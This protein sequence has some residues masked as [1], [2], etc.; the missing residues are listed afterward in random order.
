MSFFDRS[1]GSKSTF[2]GSTKPVATP[3][4]KIANN[5][6]DGDEDPKTGVQMQNSSVNFFSQ[7]SRRKNNLLQ[8][9]SPRPSTTSKGVTENCGWTF[10]TPQA[11][12]PSSEH[13][14]ASSDA[15]N[16]YHE[17]TPSPTTSK[18]IH[19]SPMEQ[20]ETPF[21]DTDISH[22]QSYQERST[23]SNQNHP[24]YSENEGI[25]GTEGSSSRSL[26]QRPPRSIHR[27]FNRSQNINVTTTTTTRNNTTT[28]TN[29][30]PRTHLDRQLTY[31]TKEMSFPNTTSNSTTTTSSINTS[32]PT[33]Q[34]QAHTQA[35]TTI[36]EE[37]EED[38]GDNSNNNSNNNCDTV[39]E[40]EMETGVVS[41]TVDNVNE[42][43][44]AVTPEN[45]N[46]NMNMMTKN[47]RTKPTHSSRYFASN[48]NYI[49][50]NNNSNTG[51]SGEYTDNNINNSRDGFG[52]ENRDKEIS[53]R[54]IGGGGTTGESN[55]TNQYSSNSSNN[56]SSRKRPV[57]FTPPPRDSHRDTSL[58][59]QRRA[60]IRTEFIQ[61]ENQEQ[62]EESRLESI[63][64][65]IS[66][67]VSPI[68]TM[69][70][71][72]NNNN[73]S[74]PKTHFT[75]PDTDNIINPMSSQPP[76]A[77]LSK[78]HKSVTRNLISMNKEQGHEHD[79]RD[80]EQEN[81]FMGTVGG[82]RD[83]QTQSQTQ[84]NRDKYYH[85]NY[86]DMGDNY[87]D[88]EYSSGRERNSGGNGN[89]TDSVSMSLHE[90]FDMNMHNNY[91]NNT[92]AVLPSNQSQSQSQTTA[93][94]TASKRV[95]LS[96][97]HQPSS[98]M[99]YSGTRRERRYTATP[100]DVSTT[101]SSSSSP[102]G[103]SNKTLEDR[104]EEL[105][106]LLVQ[107][108]RMVRSA[109][110]RHDVDNLAHANDFSRLLC[111]DGAPSLLLGIQDSESRL[112]NIK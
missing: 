34:L 76:Q 104:L 68:A 96:D 9:P 4:P 91:N 65:S 37:G 105:S 43:T 92:D 88:N 44:A 11:V 3:N 48:D 13:S 32:I 17:V 72:N 111:E 15:V 14:G 100:T 24:K 60:A 106:G 54:R 63:S 47:I 84:L 49:S 6:D 64:T 10:S 46:M 50:S 31:R 110:E 53:R 90:V 70:S 25:E 98:S 87:N 28:T 1:V 19:T 36:I 8:N 108:K 59:R 85:M 58:S 38:G 102:Y 35:I 103:T 33:T 51:C 39:M 21:S 26:Q 99:E 86:H 94:T 77:P 95:V 62:E 42:T 41:M 61:D 2:F 78:I 82:E 80:P 97:S 89:G 73:S 45:M 71:N 16:H 56:T 57:E 27:P 30:I 67:S 81:H 93:T 101:I 23:H 52:F 29:N 18:D 74:N 55:I 20:V 66:M 112:E 40:T 109:S 22:K 79:R 5:N 107:G 12:P 75:T 7:E 83:T 69:N